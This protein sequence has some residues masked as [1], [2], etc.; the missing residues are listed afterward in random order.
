[1]VAIYCRVSTDKQEKDGY[2]LMEQRQRGIQF[3]S[4]LGEEHEIYSESVSGMKRFLQRAQGKRLLGDIKDGTVNKVWVVNIDRLAR[5]TTV[6]LEILEF[7]E[8]H[9]VAFYEDGTLVDFQDAENM[10]FREIR[11]SIAAYE[12]KRI[13]NRMHSARDRSRN[14]GNH[15]Y[16]RMFGYRME[17][18]PTKRQ[19]VRWMID[20][21]QAEVVRLIYKSFVADGM[22]L[23]AICG[24]LNDEGYKTW[25]GTRFV[26]THMRRAIQRPE[27]SGRTRDSKGNLIKSN[28]YERIVDDAT[29]NA[30]QKLLGTAID[31]SYKKHV[32]HP[33]SG[34]VRCSSCGEYYY[35]HSNQSGGKM[36]PYYTHHSSGLSMKTCKQLPKCLHYDVVNGIFKYLYLRSMF[37]RSTVE[38]LYE[39]ERRQY[40]QQEDRVSKSVQRLR[41][42]IEEENGKKRRL[43]DLVEGGSIDQSEVS[44]RLKRIAETIERYKRSIEKLSKQ[45]VQSKKRYETIL[46]EFTLENAFQFLTYEKEDRANNQRNMIKRILKEASIDGTTIHIELISGEKYEIDY[47]ERRIASNVAKNIKNISIGYI[48]EIRDAEMFLDIVLGNDVEAVTRWMKKP[49]E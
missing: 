9:S 25:A 6:G 21:E 41:D 18:D 14:E 29:W 13:L 47:E 11:Q 44:D 16:V 46:A 31:R 42:N 24:R 17:H 48:K 19:K 12:R 28:V 33:C 20:K 30:A 10:L 27:Y 7:F 40:Q 15:A 1:M 22:S 35:F 36:L 39:E 2:S 3:A 26:N 49:P 45:T 4:S 5:K 34:L 37:D 38:A 32:N 43:L 8:E 23:N